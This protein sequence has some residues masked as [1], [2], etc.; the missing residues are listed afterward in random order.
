MLPVYRYIK[1][2]WNLQILLAAWWNAFE[3]TYVIKATS[4]T[5]MIVP[6][7]E[8]SFHSPQIDAGFLSLAGKRRGLVVCFFEVAAFFIVFAAFSVFVILE[9]AV[10]VVAVVFGTFII[11]NGFREILQL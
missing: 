9:I 1:K 11:V 8:G 6:F 10:G 3:E 2:A 4:W 5:L 7:P